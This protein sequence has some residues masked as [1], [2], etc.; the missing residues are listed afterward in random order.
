METRSLCAKIP[1]ELHTKVRE[2]QEKCGLTLNEYM[3]KILTEYYEKGE[4]NMN[5]HT[6][7]LALQINEELFVRVKAHLKRN[8]ISQKNFIIGI[9]E[10]ALEN[11]E[12]AM[13]SQE[14]A[15]PVLEQLPEETT[16]GTI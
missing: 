8:G 11:S 1:T 4:K 10:Q 16:E 13:A 5:E 7:T 6:R 2:N 12:K 9:I 14:E 3:I 15:E